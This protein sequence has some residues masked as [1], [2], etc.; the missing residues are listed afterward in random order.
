MTDPLTFPSHEECEECELSQAYFS[1]GLPTRFAGHPDTPV[2]F[3][4]LG[5]ALFIIGQ[6]PG[7][8]ELNTGVSWVGWT[9]SLLHKLLVQT[10]SLHERCD[11]YLSNACRCGTLRNRAP[12]QSLIKRCR[13]HLLRD[14]Q[15]VVN[16]YGASNVIVLCMGAPATYSMT[17]LSIRR[18][19]THQGQR[20]APA[21]QVKGKNN[22]QRIADIPPL[23]MF[24]TYHPARC[25]PHRDPV[26]IRTI[27]THLK[28]LVRYLDSPEKVSP[29][30]PAIE[31][32][33]SDLGATSLVSL[34]IETYGVL[35]D[36]SQTVFHPRRA[37]SVDGVPYSKQIAGVSLAWR[38]PQH[39]LHASW[40]SLQQLSHRRAFA[41]ALRRLPRST[42]LLGTNIPFDLVFLRACYPELRLLLKFGRF[43]LEDLI[44][45]NHL[46]DDL[47]V[48]RSLKAVSNLLGT[49]DYAKLVVST[50]PNGQK[51]VSPND[52][53]LHYYCCTDACSALRSCELMLADLN[54]RWSPELPGIP[55]SQFRSDLVWLLTHMQEVGQAFSL[56]ALR[57]LHSELTA[58]V[59]K[60]AWTCAQHGYTIVGK[61][62]QRPTYKLMVHALQEAGFE[63]S[64]SRIKLTDAKREISTGAE[65]IALV[66]GDGKTDHGVLPPTAYTYSPMIAFRDF[67]EVAAT[68]R[69]YASPL[70]HKPDRGCDSR[71]FAYP[72]WFP[73]PSYPKDEAGKPGGTKQC[74]FAAHNPAAQTYPPPISKCQVSR[75]GSEGVLVC[76]DLSQIEL[77]TAALLSN[78]Q[79]MIDCYL[80]GDDLHLDSARGVWSDLTVDHPDYDD[81]RALGKMLNFRTLYRGGAEGL[82]EAARRLAGINLTPLE[83]VDIVSRFWEHRSR[84]REWQDEL[85]ALAS[86]QGYLELPTGWFRSFPRDKYL[87]ESTYT[88]EICNFPVQAIGSGQ[89]PQSCQIALLHYQ[90]T[91]RLAFCMPSQ[92]HDGIYLDIH[93]SCLPEV[94][95]LVDEVF[96]RPPLWE[97]LCEHLG[98]YVPV[99]YSSEQL[100]PKETP[101]ES[102]SSS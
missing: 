54:E 60:A 19:A 50:L 42:T 25:T 88:N 65:N 63:L 8:E 84:L 52:P 97:R 72:S 7:T 3:L 69:N 55:R 83:A 92:S 99:C 91:R 101:N 39:R 40:Y 59:N 89:V 28:L 44:I 75:Y 79:S 48:E 68:L 49:G 94:T 31:S 30:I 45:L 102:P 11:I 85:I 15:R 12:K 98:R 67:K 74:R 26:A 17:G 58:K 57:S 46:H 14:L 53:N 37:L 38:D 2:P 82:P 62:S 47:R 95:A 61:G 33:P 9:G 20:F 18:A 64:D 87:T 32:A 34:D 24:F 29:S 81:R 86:K 16:H 76:Y 80:R 35:Q 70:L 51:A 36:R 73:A 100:W 41:A 13:P 90:T 22:P 71:G 10:Y 66:V 56:D 43:K 4:N 27:D 78:E 23:P 96:T 77:R 21:G 93:R 1:R 6:N 5:K